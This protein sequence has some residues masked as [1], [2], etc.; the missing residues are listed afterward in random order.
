MDYPFFNSKALS[1]NNVYD[2]T[3]PID[4]LKYFHTKLGTKIE[5]LKSY[6]DSN[7]FIS[8]MLAKK[9][10]GKGTYAK[11]V[12]DV[13]GP[14]RIAHI[15][16]GDVIRKIHVQLD[17][18]TALQELRSYLEKN[19]RGFLSI[20]DALETLK[21]RTQD[22]VS[23]PTDFLLC[24][25]K[26]EI[27]LMG[28]K[29]LFIDGLPRNLDQITASL[30]FRDLVNYRDDPD[31]FILIDTPNEILNA[32][33]KNRRVC[34]YCQTS[35]NL[36]FTPSQFVKYD[37]LADDYYFV[38]DNTLCSGYGVARYI[39]KEGDLD[40]ISSIEERLQAD[41]DLMAVA[42]T[43]QGIP[44]IMLRST[45]PVAI[46]KEYLE[47]YEIQPKL[48]YSVQGDKVALSKEN[49]VFKDENGEECYTIYAATYVVNLLT[50]LHKI[51]LG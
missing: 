14:T 1:D 33:M 40:G 28:K 18:P 4:R 30:Y 5:D 36:L 17:D 2:L 46:A 6:L 7:S 9:L 44:K 42:V 8:Y 24:L 48:V 3:D 32:R 19:Y 38:C 12:A 29:A 25:L 39:A 47:D 23:I 31:L 11:M 51:L 37:K 13:L 15:S 10:A 34:P 16:V 49:W 43:L 45:Y 22:K 41:A 50:S 26:N 20:D 27:T 21:N 35:R